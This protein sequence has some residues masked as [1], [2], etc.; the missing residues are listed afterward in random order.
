MTEFAEAKPACEH[1]WADHCYGG[2]SVRL[3]QFCHEPD[4]DDLRRQL[5][6]ARAMRAHADPPWWWRPW[7]RPWYAWRAWWYRE[8]PVT[9]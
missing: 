5:T 9:R 4:W 1:Y 2:L 6:E 3:C 7:L 8:R